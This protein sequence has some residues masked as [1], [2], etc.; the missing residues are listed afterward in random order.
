MNA[1]IPCKEISVFLTR[2]SPAPLSR[3]HRTVCM[4]CEETSLDTVYLY[5]GFSEIAISVVVAVKGSLLR[6]Q[7][8]ENRVRRDDKCCV[9]FAIVANKK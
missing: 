6:E 5:V 7:I 4:V 3:K 8:V 2:L 1:M 9:D